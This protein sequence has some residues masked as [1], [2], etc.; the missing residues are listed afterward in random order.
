[1]NKM[2]SNSELTA[3]RRQL[4]QA[5]SAVSLGAFSP[6]LSIASS[7]KSSTLTGTVFDLTLSDIAVN[8][9]GKRRIG[10]AINGQIPG[11]T[12]RMREGESIT[13]RVKNK[14]SVTSSIHWH[15]LILPTNMDGVPG[16]SFAGIKPGETYVYRFKAVQSGTYWYHSHSGFQEQTGL[17]GSIVIE[18]KEQS[19]M[20]PY[21][22]DHVVLLSDWS[23]ENPN[24]I[25]AKLKKLSEYYS[26]RERTVG[27]F[28]A[29]VANKGLSQT[30]S[31]RQMWNTMRMSDRD[32]SD[33][34]GWT[35]S[36]LT[37][38]HSPRDGWVGDF[39]PG[40]RVRL[41]FINASAMTIFDVRI[42]GL[43]MQVVASDGQEVQP[44]D[45]IE[46]IRIGV[47]E[48]YDV[49]VTP[50]AG[51][52]T[53]FSQAIDRSGYALGTLTSNPNKRASIPNL[54]AMPTLTHTDMG[55]GSMGSMEGMDH[56]S[57]Q[58]MDHSNMQMDGDSNANVTIQTG[59]QVD[60]LAFDAQT[61]L[62]DPGIGLRGN[63]RRVLTYADLRNRYPT[64]DRRSPSREIELHLT[65]NMSRYMWSINGVRY[66]DAPPIALRYGERVRFTLINDT[67]MNHPVHLHGMWSELEINDTNYLPKKHTILAQPGAKISYLV[68]ADA[69]GQWAYHCHL[70]FHAKGM[71]RRVVVS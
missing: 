44:V 2:N 58:G 6:N 59:V 23:D 10:T 67:M 33:V 21:D 69:I 5:I 22:R 53:I 31:D 71:F 61:R 17:Y 62:D 7:P 49:I 25:Y 68:T 40:E 35:Y 26:T 15:G 48:T 38:G 63:G 64:E 66:A 1:M 28:A 47:A 32:I 42:P 65:G 36:F 12:L 30:I 56:G 13:I 70:L 50:Q 55:M 4:L 39:R 37:N 19:L 20:A 43:K 8:I 60:M 51:A 57:M 46:E 45:G 9:T 24:Q 11:P 18:P 3:N 54:D 52:H 34:T 41:R 27:D 14:M 29:D 16:L